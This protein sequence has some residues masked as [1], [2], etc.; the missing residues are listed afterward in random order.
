MKKKI[1]FCYKCTLK[2]PIENINDPIFKLLFQCD[3]IK[4]I[5]EFYEKDDYDENISIDRDK[6]EVKKFLYFNKEAVHKLLYDSN[7]LYEI[8]SKEEISLSELFYLSLLVLD[9]PE[10][11]NYTYSLDYIKYIFNKYKNDSNLKQ[12]EKIVISKIILILIFNYKGEDEY[13]ENN[14]KE[15]L[16][17]IEKENKQIIEENLNIFNQLNINYSLKDIINKNI[18]NIYLEVISSLIK[19]NKF[20][21]Y[22]FCDNILSQL[23]LENIYITQTI[24]EGINKVLNSGEKY[25]D[26]Y[27]IN[28]KNDILD[29]DKVCFYYFLIKSVFKNSLYIYRSNFLFKNITKIQKIIKE[30]NKELNNSN[31]FMAEKIKEIINN[32]YIY[33]KFLIEQNDVPYSGSLNQYCSKGREKCDGGKLYQ[34]NNNTVSEQKGKNTNKKFS[35]DIAVK[36]LEGL[37]LKIQ[38]FPYNENDDKDDLEKPNF[39]YKGI[40]YL[41]S[42]KLDDFDILKINIDDRDRNVITDEDL[43]HE[44]AKK[45]FKNYRRLLNFIKE[46]ECYINKNKKEILFNPQIELELIREI[47][48]PINDQ[49]ENK[50]IYNMTCISTFIN[51]INNQKMTYKDENILVYTINGKSQGFINLISELSNDDYKEE[52]FKY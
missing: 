35:Y 16:E 38:I 3:D 19:E 26:N 40:T 12:L 17:S 46:I 24:Y 27:I 36:I 34:M 18:D 9:I 10:T 37:R 44:D 22:K 30:K 25:M 13:D 5:N 8:K 21:N 4:E 14:D 32:D 48:K 2:N 29:K 15:E 31:D 28:D 47:N 11:I 52:T 23:D 1:E 42:N 50:D 49:S 51:Q 7:D 20:K 33:E 6:K 39:E 43:K 41:N 45:V